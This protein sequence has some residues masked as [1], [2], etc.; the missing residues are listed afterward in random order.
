LQN[1]IGK[2]QDCLLD[3]GQ[4][5]TTYD[6]EGRIPARLPN[7]QASTLFPGVLMAAASRLGP[8]PSLQSRQSI[9]KK[10]NDTK[11][12]QGLI[13]KN[14]I[15][16]GTGWWAAYGFNY[17]AWTSDLL[18]GDAPAARKSFWSDDIGSSLNTEVRLLIQEIGE[19]YTRNELVSNQIALFDPERGR[20]DET[21]WQKTFL[22]ISLETLYGILQNM[23]PAE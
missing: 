19:P 13:L 5:A 22:L 14:S 12:V 21:Q 1:A 17:L 11:V 8:S 4:P 7:T 2:L 16:D 6:T 20:S 9:L 3:G 10:M 18:T 15:K 23:P